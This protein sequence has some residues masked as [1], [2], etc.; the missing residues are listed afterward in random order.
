MV[1]NDN[2]ISRYRA[3]II[4]G[5]DMESIL[6]RVASFANGCSNMVIESSLKSV[7]SRVCRDASYVELN[8]YSDVDK[9]ILSREEGKVI[10]F[11]VSSPRS[12]VYAVALIL[13]DRFNKS[14]VSGGG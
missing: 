11:Q 8:G 4:Y 13:V 12:D 9:A 5:K 6:R 14:R 2:D 1:L 10:V 3:Y 7:A